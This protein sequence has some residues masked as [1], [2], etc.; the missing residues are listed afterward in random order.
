MIDIPTYTLFNCQKILQ[1]GAIII[2]TYQIFKKMK[3]R[4][5]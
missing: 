1:V 3:I 4:K 5:G 2:S